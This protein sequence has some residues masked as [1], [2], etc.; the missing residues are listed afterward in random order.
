MVPN[1][2]SQIPAFLP[3]KLKPSAQVRAHFPLN[4]K[5]V[6]LSRYSSS[7]NPSPK[8]DSLKS[9]YRVPTDFTIN[10]ERRSTAMIFS[11]VYEVSSSRLSSQVCTSSTRRSKSSPRLFSSFVRTGLFKRSCIRDLLLSADAIMIMGV[12]PSDDFQ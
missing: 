8:L 3:R 4:T 6:S 9:L 11:L 10:W 5:P 2:W 12:P 1:Q 7:I